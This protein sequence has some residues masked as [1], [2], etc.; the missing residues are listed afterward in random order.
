[1]DLGTALPRDEKSVRQSMVDSIINNPTFLSLAEE[2]RFQKI[3]ER[4]KNNLYGGGIWKQ[5]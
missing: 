1:M 4:L 2:D 3:K 5:S